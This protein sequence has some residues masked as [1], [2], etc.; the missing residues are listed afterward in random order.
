MPPAMPPAMPLPTRFRQFSLATLVATLAV[1][2][3]GA[4]V[5]AT[6]SG[7]GCGSHWPTCNGEVLH[8]PESIATL[9][10]L[11]H[12][13]T[14]G[15]SFVLVLIQ[16]VWARRLFPK[17][18]L[19]RLGA[20][21]SMLFM[22]TE[23]AVGAGL[24]LFELVAQDASIARGFS[25][26]V[27][28]VNTFLLVASLTLTVDWAGGAR[29]PRFGGQVPHR[30]LV[31]LAALLAMVVGVTGA[32]AALGDT[33]FPSQTLVEGLASDL[34]AT[35][36]IF[37]RLR[38]LHPFAAAGLSL[39][40]LVLASSVS[41]TLRSPRGKRRASVLA[42]LA[43]LQVGVG[44]L[45]LLLLAP[46]AMQLVHLFLAD[47]LWIALVLLGN[48]VLSQEPKTEQPDAAAEA[49]Q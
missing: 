14:S 41:P 42:V 7:A 34:S 19:V 36:H 21:L 44:L 17:G 35:A 20:G 47:A 5:R 18:H 3:W 45:N 37:L 26:S 27:H 40:L 33:L 22:I 6:G 15:L 10:E 43:I 29:A 48:E 12:R 31:V 2:L 32:I 28:L 39:F 16:L 8:R 23:A 9:I 25:I 46:I 11:T 13:V 1:I 24:V 4:Y 30:T 38:T 49:V